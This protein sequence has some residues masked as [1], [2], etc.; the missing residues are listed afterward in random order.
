MAS[1]KIKNIS[2]SELDWFQNIFTAYGLRLLGDMKL[3]VK[4]KNK[5]DKRETTIVKNK[6]LQLF[7]KTCCL[8]DRN[9]H[10]YEVYAEDLHS[11]YEFFTEKINSEEKLS[12]ISFNK[13]IKNT[14]F[15]YK[16]PHHSRKDNRYAFLGITLK[17]NWTEA[18]I[19]ELN[20][21]HMNVSYTYFTKYIDHITS[22]ILTDLNS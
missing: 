3:G 12:F 20:P 4:R 9:N 11:A 10:H 7:F 2:L 21:S 13:T 14:G 19:P 22:T 5:P 16:R 18:I 1:Q 17:E 6:H 8:I 15:I